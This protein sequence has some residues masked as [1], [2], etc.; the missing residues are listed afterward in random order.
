MDIY[1]ARDE[2]IH[3]VE[4]AGLEV[5]WAEFGPEMAEFGVT[6]QDE[7]FQVTVRRAQ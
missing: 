4:K 6:I 2:L 5:P 7:T 1:E 3:A